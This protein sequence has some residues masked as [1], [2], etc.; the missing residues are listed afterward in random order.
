MLCP[1]G[2]GNCRTFPHA[3]NTNRTNFMA[4]KSIEEKVKDIIVE[5]LFQ[6]VVGAAFRRGRFRSTKKHGSGR[7]FCLWVAKKGKRLRLISDE[8]L[9][10]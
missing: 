9:A 10:F 3:I 2:A 6:T 7:V 1:D 4:E 5:Q 8:L